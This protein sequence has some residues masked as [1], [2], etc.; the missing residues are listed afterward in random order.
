MEEDLEQIK[1]N[2]KKY[3][4]NSKILKIPEELIDIEVIKIGGYSN[5]NY[6]AVIKNKTKNEII[7]QIFYRKFGSKLE[8]FLNQ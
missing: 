6:R 7:D 8:H 1:S 4:S 2:I 3:I 5:M